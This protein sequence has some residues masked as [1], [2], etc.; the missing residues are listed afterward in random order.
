MNGI[1]EGARRGPDTGSVVA[2]RITVDRPLPTPRWMT[3]AGRSPSSPRLSSFPRPN[4]PRPDLDPSLSLSGPLIGP[5]VS[6]SL[7][8]SYRFGTPHADSPLRAFVHYPLASGPS[9]VSWENPPPVRPTKSP[10]SSRSLEGVRAITEV[11]SP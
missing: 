11:K 10:G 1:G 4:S 2:E 9:P 6:R 3:N 8:S 7:T 5:L